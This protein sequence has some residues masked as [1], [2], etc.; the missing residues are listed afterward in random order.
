[1]NDE[2]Y[3]ESS[4]V[5][6][7]NIVISWNRHTCIIVILCMTKECYPLLVR[8]QPLIV[9]P[10]NQAIND[11]SHFLLMN[12]IVYKNKEN[13]PFVRVNIIAF[14]WKKGPNC[15]QDN[16]L[17]SPEFLWIMK[18]YQSHY[19][20]SKDVISYRTLLLRYLILNTIE[21]TKSHFYVV[22]ICIPRKKDSKTTIFWECSQRDPSLVTYRSRR[23]SELLRAGMTPIHTLQILQRSAQ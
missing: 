17:I 22:V 20:F 1:M 10:A 7:E 9:I 23:Q 3:N 19:H 18:S 5:N 8:S 15:N 14:I 2:P 11:K 4:F 6:N 13:L 16:P 21:I 12:V